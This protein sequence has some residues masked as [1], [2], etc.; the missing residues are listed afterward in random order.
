MSH[1]RFLYNEAAGPGKRNARIVTIK[2]LPKAIG[3]RIDAHSTSFWAATQNVGK[4][5]GGFGLLERQ[6]AIVWLKNAHDQFDR[7]GL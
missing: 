4:D 1:L 7:L 3:S 2:R 6:R 5:T